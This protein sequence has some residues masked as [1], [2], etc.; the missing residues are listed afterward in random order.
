MTENSEPPRSFESTTANQVTL[1]SPKE[2]ADA[3]PY[4]MGFYPNDSVVMVALHGR[5]GRFGGR[6]RLGIPDHREEWREVSE[7]LAECLISGSE[8]R[9]GKPDGVVLFLCQEPTGDQSAQEVMEWLRPLAQRLR[10][11]CGTRD[12]PVLEALC[13]SDGRYWSYCC[14][15][16]RCCPAEGAPL[17]LSG[18]S[19]MAAAATY[20]GLRVRGSLSEMEARFA[21]PSGPGGEEQEK[22]LDEAAAD[23]VP[24]IL[25]GEDREVVETETLELVRLLL[26]RFAGVLPEGD[27]PEGDAVDDGLL[28][29]EEAAAVVLGLQDRTTRDRAAEWMEG[30]EAAPAL[31]LWR[32]LAR[33][34]VGAYADHAAAPLTLAGWVAWSTG[35]EPTARVALALAL[36]ADPDYVFARLLH[37]GVNEGLDPEQLRSCLREERA[38]RDARRAPDAPPAA[39]QQAPPGAPAARRPRKK[40]LRCRRPVRSGTA[41]GGTSRSRPAGRRAAFRGSRSRGARSRR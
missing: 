41:R 16:P 34:C 26:T 24:R 10:R 36:Q 4:L 29:P 1:R 6:L 37:Q 13:V 3:L 8:K 9:T 23:L 32:A 33:R 38:E 27:G 19:V 21:P 39:S 30:P 40:A 11:A 7:Q 5:R 18:T 22:A 2:L 28:A 14:P 15:D 20:A 31:R 25:G 12:V 17:A 35:D